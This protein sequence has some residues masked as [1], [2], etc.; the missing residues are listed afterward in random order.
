M[1][2]LAGLRREP[3]RPHFPDCNGHQH[4]TD[5]RHRSELDTVQDTRS[6]QQQQ[7]KRHA[8][9]GDRHDPGTTRR[10]AIASTTAAMS[11]TAN[12]TND[13]TSNCVHGSWYDDAEKFAMATGA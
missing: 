12:V 10:T 11:T 13:H 6:G 2:G 4:H 1:V 9:R 5:G 3:A 8:R 7:S